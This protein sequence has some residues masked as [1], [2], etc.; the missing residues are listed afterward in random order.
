MEVADE[1]LRDATLKLRDA[2]SGSAEN[3]QNISVAT[4]ML[5]TAKTKR[6]HAVLKLSNLRDKKKFRR[7][8]LV[9]CY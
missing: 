5:K 8:K 4:T 7:V 2:V 6:D 1:L 9:I 3:R